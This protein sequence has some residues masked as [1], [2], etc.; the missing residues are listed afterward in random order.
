MRRLKRLGVPILVTVIGLGG[1]A[2]TGWMII[3]QRD[4]RLIHFVTCFMFL[5]TVVFVLYVTYREGV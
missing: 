4:H 2:F 5:V 3:V 1:A